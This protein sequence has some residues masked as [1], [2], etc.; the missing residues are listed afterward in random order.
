MEHVLV[1]TR[2]LLDQ[3]GSFQGFQPEVNRYLEAMLAP[4][5]NF[6]MERPAAELDPTHKQLIPY[7]SATHEAGSRVKSALFQNAPLVSAGISI[8]WIKVMMA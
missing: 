8:P 1:I 6:F 3:L 5:A 4:G 7:R 2:A